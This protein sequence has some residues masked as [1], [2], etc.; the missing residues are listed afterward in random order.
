MSWLFSQALVEEFSAASCLD[1]KP[2]ALLSGNP[3]QQAYCA[4]DKMT[5]FSRLSRFGMTFKPLTA[6]RGEA[7]LMSY[8]AGFHAKTS[9]Q[10]EKEQE[11]PA[12]GQDS[13]LKW[14]GLLAKYNH[15][16]RSWKTAQSS[17]L[18]DLEQSLEIW[19][20]WGSMRNGV[21]YQQQT[22]VRRTSEKESGLW[23]TPDT[24]GF[25]NEGS[26]AMLAKKAGSH[27]EY[28]AMG[29]RAAAKKKEK[30]WPT[31]SAS[32]NRDRGNLSTPAIQR[33]LSKGKQLMLSM[34]V[35]EVSGQLNPTWVEK[36]MGWP[37]DWTSLQPMS[38]VKMCFWLM[39]SHNGTETGRSEVLRVLRIGNAAQEIQREIGRPVGVH[40]AALL[41]AELCE[42]AN[43]PD[44]ARVFMACAK[45]LEEELRGVQLREGTTGAPHR[46]RQNQQRAGEHPDSVQALSRF[47]AHHGQT[48]WQDGRWEDAT[49]RVAHGV[50]ARVDRLKSIGNGQV[51]AVAATAW[52]ILNAP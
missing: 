40:E 3:I 36:L 48:Y 17:L 24:R 28:V 12:A 51:P 38:H 14:Q 31:P 30:Y 10:Q 18:A 39:G 33:R 21:S 46:P 20:R 22:L 26:I 23:P 29:Y 1:G 7:L 47:L 44:E 15:A 4:P 6:D 9:P 41:L 19:P 43:R 35:S 50:A 5:D 37:D 32:D 49:L 27:A 2:S 8:L 13:G 45:A 52:R 11:S 42:H 16:T 25:V 34:V